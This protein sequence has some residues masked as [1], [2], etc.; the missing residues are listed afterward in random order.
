MLI[1]LLDFFGRDTK[2]RTDAFLV[3]RMQEQSM[4]ELLY[5][6]EL[7]LTEVNQKLGDTLIDSVENYLN[8][9]D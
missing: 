8:R 3:T 2:D 7:M 9:M 4:L 1:F 6:N 5:T